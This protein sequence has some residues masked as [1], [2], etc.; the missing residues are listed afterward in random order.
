M[1]QPSQLP[2]VEEVT[3]VHSARATAKAPPKP[4]PL[5]D[6]SR[7]AE[8]EAILDTLKE[9]GGNKRMAARALNVSYKTLFNKLHQ[10]N[11]TT[12][13]EYQ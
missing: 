12:K 5:K 6:A 11:I 13:K 9:C 1:P 10:F 8:R 4:N 2:T 3:G 7:A